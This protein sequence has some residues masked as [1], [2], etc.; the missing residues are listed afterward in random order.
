MRLRI[1]LLWA[2]YQA[3][4][5]QVGV[6]MSTFS[7]LMTAGIF[8]TTT[9]QHYV[10]LFWYAVLLIGAVALMVVFSLLIGIPG[11]YAY[12]RNQSKLDKMEQELKAIRKLLEE[13]C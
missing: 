10:P 1:G 12:F 2:Q 6:L 3:L 9:A 5:G 8:W 7:Y 11:Q 4:Y 13:K